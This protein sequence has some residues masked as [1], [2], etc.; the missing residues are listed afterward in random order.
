MYWEGNWCA[1]CRGCIGSEIGM[2]GVEDV[3]GV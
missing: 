2:Q 3:L 1:G